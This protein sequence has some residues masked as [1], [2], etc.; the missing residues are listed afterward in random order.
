MTK[1]I[2]NHNDWI[3][4]SLN[5]RYYDEDNGFVVEVVLDSNGVK[6]L[7]SST[8]IVDDGNCYY[9]DLSCNS[10][11]NRAYNNIFCDKHDVFDDD[12]IYIDIEIPE[13][14]INHCAKLI[15]TDKEHDSIF[16]NAFKNGQAFDSVNDMY[17]VVFQYLTDHNE[18][19]NRWKIYDILNVGDN[20]GYATY[21]HNDKKY[22]VIM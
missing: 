2:I 10:F 4:D 11:A 17:A 22:H 13:W 8:S 1:Y 5:P 16:V 18:D 3:Y 15:E 7:G 19:N 9:Y 20:M 14:F 21:N 12:E 6:L